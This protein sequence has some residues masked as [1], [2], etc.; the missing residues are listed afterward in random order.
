MVGIPVFAVY[1]V[2]FT[3]T[4]EIDPATDEVRNEATATA[5]VLVVGFLGAVVSGVYSWLLNGSAK[6][7]T[8]GKMALS[9]Q[10]RDARTGGPI[11][12][13]RGFLRSLVATV[14]WLVLVLPGLLDVL[15]PL[16]DPRRQSWHDKAAGSVV[17]RLP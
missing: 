8:L 7:Q 15:S 4:V 14:L 12:L 6:G 2:V 10:V 13:G 5:V 1:L 17:V 3:A 9:L 16:W 11:G